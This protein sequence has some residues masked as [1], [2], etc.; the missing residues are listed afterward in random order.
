MNGG[1]IIASPNLLCRDSFLECVDNIGDQSAGDTMV[2]GQKGVLLEKALAAETAITAFAQVQEG[3]FRQR[4]IFDFLHSIVMDEV[5]FCAAGR[6]AVFAAR[7]FDR[8]VEL[9]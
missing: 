2:T 8:D 6:A 7:Q 4:D 1:D 5:C 3:V 9:I